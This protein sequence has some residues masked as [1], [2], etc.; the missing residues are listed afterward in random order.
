MDDMLDDPLFEDLERV[1]P[2]NSFEVNICDIFY[3]EERKWDIITHH[4]DKASIYDTDGN[5]NNDLILPYTSYDQEDMI[6]DIFEPF[7]DLL[8]DVPRLYL[9]HIN[10]EH[11]EPT[12]VNPIEFDY[13]D[14]KPS[15]QDLVC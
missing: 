7:L 8:V 9:G 6:V 11:D 15:G 3:I 14:R 4:F 2:T 10:F 5:V 1:D 12:L 13:C